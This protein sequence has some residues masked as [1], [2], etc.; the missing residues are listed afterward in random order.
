MIRQ[1]HPQRRLA[2]PVHGRPVGT[3]PAGSIIRLIVPRVRDYGRVIVEG[4][5]P[6]E[7]GASRRNPSTG[8][9]EST[10]MAGGHLAIV[11]RLANGQRLTVAEQ[12]LRED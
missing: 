10:R 3:V 9:Y 2:R 11:R 1:Y 4:W 12:Y 8:L 6:R 7:M 5:V